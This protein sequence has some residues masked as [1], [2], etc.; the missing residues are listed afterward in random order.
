MSSI[1]EFLKQAEMFI[2]LSDDELDRVA[3]LCRSQFFEADSPIIE[4]NSAPDHFY[5]IQE[6][7][8]KISATQEAENDD[9]TQQVTVTLGKGQ[10]FGEM[11]L[12]DRGPRSATVIA[13]I[14]TQVLAIDCQRFLNLCEKDTNM[15]YMVMRNIATDLSFKLRH[16]NLI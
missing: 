3:Q 9:P 13:A 5:L 15:G 1:K 7:T 11:S 10:S 4:R 6:G 16:R 14:P 12:I 2:G 8:V